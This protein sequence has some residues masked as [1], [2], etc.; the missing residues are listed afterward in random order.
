MK[1]A[2]Y[3]D[4]DTMH[5]NI[6]AIA[7]L[8]SKDPDTRHGAVI[9]DKFNRVISVGYNGFPRQCCDDE[10]PWTKPEKYNYSVHAEA[11]AIYNAPQDI[12]G[13]TLYLFSEKGYYPCANCAQAIVQKGITKVVVAF[14][15][16]VNTEVYNWDHTKKM[17]DS[18]NIVC[19]SLD[20]FQL[21]YQRK[22]KRECYDD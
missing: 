21:C 2:D 18:A 9:V 19:V 7:A 1:R 12:K 11:N 22:F 14:T 10:F 13:C 20:N 6:A 4:W 8:R 15:I 5:M 17:F 16:K 3:I